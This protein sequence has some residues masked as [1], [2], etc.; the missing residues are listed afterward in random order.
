MVSDK[1]YGDAATRYDAEREDT[2]RWAKER[3]AVSDLVTLEP[4][5]D[6]PL[7]TGRYIPLY[8]S[9]RLDFIGLDISPDMLAVTRERY[10]YSGELGNILSLPYEAG[11]FG[12][13]VCTRLLDWLCPDDMVKALT[14]LRRVAQSLLFTVRHGDE[15]I[16]INYTHDLTRVYAALDGFFIA[17]RR[18]TEITRHGHEEIIY[19][20][21]PIWRDVLAQFQWH[22]PD[23][24]AEMERIA[25]HTID[26]GLTTI[27]AEYWTAEQAGAALDDMGGLSP[28]YVDCPEPR[29]FD[30][31]AVVLVRGGKQNIL[32]GQRRLNAMRGAKGRHPVLVLRTC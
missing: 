26:K 7:G 28:K 22:G 14:E 16:S 15:G 19:A 21:A 20:R 3:Q 11:S 32:D 13:A 8:R 24:F 27:S 6:V 25:G 1:Y 2:A 31:T 10:G 23:R 5:L 17:D 18:T 29:F 9:K 4:V 30:G 12:T